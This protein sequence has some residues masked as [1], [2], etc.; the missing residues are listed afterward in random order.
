MGPTAAGSRYYFCTRQRAEFAKIAIFAN[1]LC[2]GI[3]RGNCKNCKSF[4]KIIGHMGYFGKTSG[5][6]GDV[7]NFAKFAKRPLQ[8]GQA[9]ICTRTRL[10]KK[11]GAIW[12]FGSIMRSGE[13]RCAKCTVSGV[14]DCAIR[15]KILLDFF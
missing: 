8:L 1:G 7:A 11:R 12:G 10:A 5:R 14:K 15:R 6:A 9:A 4:C 13:G 2:V 3:M